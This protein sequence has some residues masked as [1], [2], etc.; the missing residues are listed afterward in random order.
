MA[1]V[2]Q[3][4]SVYFLV[5]R[6][7]CN[8]PDVMKKLGLTIGVEGKRVA[9][10]GLGNVGYHSAKFFQDA[11]AKIIGLQNMKVLSWNDRWIG[12]R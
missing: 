5:L 4:V 11:G 1:V 6:E 10:Q 9:V 7:V 2:K 3:Q 12:C 8:M